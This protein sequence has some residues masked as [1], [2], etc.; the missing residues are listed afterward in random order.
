M[1]RSMGVGIVWR[2]HVGLDTP[3]VVARDTW[4]FLLPYVREADL[5]IFSRRVFAWDGLYAARIRVVAPSIDPFSPKNCELDNETIEAVLT[6]AGVVDGRHGD[7]TFTRLDGTRAH[8]QH[9]ATMVESRSST[10][11]RRWWRRCPDGIAD[12]GSVCWRPSYKVSSR[13]AMPT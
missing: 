1:L 2:C 5:Y 6:A 3:N 11:Q 4:E 9:V 10:L 13:R 12:T 8:V 7:A